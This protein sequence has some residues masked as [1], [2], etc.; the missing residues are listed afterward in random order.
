MFDQDENETSMNYLNAVLY[1]LQQQPALSQ[2]LEGDVYYKNMDGEVN[3][4]RE[5]GNQLLTVIQKLLKDHVSVEQVVFFF[6]QVL[7]FFSSWFKTCY[8]EVGNGDPDSLVFSPIKV[9]SPEALQNV[10]KHTRGL[11][12]RFI[13]FHRSCINQKI[14]LDIKQLRKTIVD[15]MT[16]FRS[17]EEIE[18]QKA[19]F[20]SAVEKQADARECFMVLCIQTLPIMA[21]MEGKIVRI[22]E[23]LSLQQPRK[24]TPAIVSLQAIQIQLW[25]SGVDLSFF[26]ELYEKKFGLQIN[27]YFDKGVT[28]EAKKI[29]LKRLKDLLPKAD[30][31]SFSKF[32][33]AWVPFLAFFMQ[34]EVKSE[35]YKEYKKT[36]ADEDLIELSN[37]SLNLI[38]SITSISDIFYLWSGLT[39][40]GLRLSLT[41]KKIT[42]QQHSQHLVA[43]IKI[44]QQLDLVQQVTFFKNI[45]EYCM[46]CMGLPMLFHGHDVYL[47]IYKLVSTIQNIIDEAS[48]EV[49]INVSDLSKEIIMSDADVLWI[50]SEL[51]E[52]FSNYWPIIKTF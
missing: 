43:L 42:P 48:L 45:C 16:P 1:F 52:I 18:K 37:S 25:Q 14:E 49:A 20:R 27:F 13:T 22:T 8:S 40:K 35:Y 38:T 24:L 11:I 30:Q 15:L 9:P 41:H 19:E 2:L 32:Y 33:V 39:I 31:M 21:E 17:A 23:T 34:L 3:P 5:N 6:Q 51:K 4:P 50:L 47:K 26:K 44:A 12:E 28:D 10:S 7:E 29:N 46:N 36:Q